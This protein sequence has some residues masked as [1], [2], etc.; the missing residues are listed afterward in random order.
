[1]RCT[2]CGREDFAGCRGMCGP[3]DYDPPIDLENGR[4][5][6]LHAERISRKCWLEACTRRAKTRVALARLRRAA[7]ERQKAAKQ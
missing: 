1:V 3:W 6:N 2:F 5:L 7:R 4:R